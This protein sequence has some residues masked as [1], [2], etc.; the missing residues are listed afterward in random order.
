MPVVE[1]T[2]KLTDIINRA[3]GSEGMVG[4]RAGILTH[5]NTQNAGAGLEP[6]FHVLNRFLFCIHIFLLLNCS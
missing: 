4:D 3:D 1:I 2:M 6:I 5:V